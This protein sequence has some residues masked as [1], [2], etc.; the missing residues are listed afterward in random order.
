MVHIIRKNGE[1]VCGKNGWL[2]K[3]EGREYTVIIMKKNMLV[4]K[5]DSTSVWNAENGRC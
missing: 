2:E 1:M 4:L 5:C 3:K